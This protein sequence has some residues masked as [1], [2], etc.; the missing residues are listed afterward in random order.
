M[1]ET[2]FTKIIN[3]EVPCHK[4]YEDEKN[5]AFLDIHP[6]QPGHVL[7]VSKTPSPTFL[8]LNEVDA[9]ALWYAVRKVAAR[10]KQVF[11]DKKR[12]GVM[13]EGLD[14]PHVHVKVF[15]IDTDDDFRR[16]PD[17]QAEPDHEALEIMAHKIAF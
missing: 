8:D 1:E 13:I 3:G 12:I 14:V 4:V 10:L 16:S 5:F 6:I 17:M 15:P 11:P 7:V 9:N 2:I